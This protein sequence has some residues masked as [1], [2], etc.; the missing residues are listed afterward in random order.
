MVV[1]SAPSAWTARTVQDLTASPLRWHVHAPQLDVSQPT[2]VPVS[3]RVSRRKWTRSRR[4]STSALSCAPFT[5]IVTRT[6]PAMRLLPVGK[7]GGPYRSGGAADLGGAAA[8]E[9]EGQLRQ[10]QP[11]LGLDVGEAQRDVGVRD[12][13]RL[14]RR[15]DLATGLDQPDHHVVEVGL[16]VAGLPGD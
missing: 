4:G 5:V 1:T 16:A 11:I 14:G 8:V 6:E 2:C 3:P 13:H 10:Q 12:A 7:P 15:L 9:G